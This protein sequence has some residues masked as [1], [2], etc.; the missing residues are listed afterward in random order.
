M[1]AQVLFSDAEIALTWSETDELKRDFGPKAATLAALPREWTPAFALIAANGS[2]ERVPLPIRAEDVSRIEK[3][4]QITGK[5]YVRSSVIGETIWDR[6]SFESVIIDAHSNNFGA[7]LH[8]AMEQVQAS[9]PTKRVGFVLQSYVQPQA[10]GEFGNLLRVSK[11]RDQWELSTEARGMTSRVRFNTQR[12]E[13]ANSIVQK[14]F[15]VGEGL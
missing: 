7:Q 14:G 3:I 9:A 15:Q 6:G 8:S 10:R 4:A 2:K 1:N 5:L 12:D 13:A 11:T